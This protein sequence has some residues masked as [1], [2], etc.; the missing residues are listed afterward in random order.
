M[1]ISKVEDQTAKSKRKIKGIHETRPPGNQKITNLKL[2]G[3]EERE[4]SQLQVL[5]NIFNKI[6]EENFPN[7]REEKSINIEEAETKL[8]I[9]EQKRK[10]S[11]PIKIKTLNLQ[12]EK[13]RLLKGGQKKGRLH[14]KEDPSEL[15]RTSQ[16]N[17]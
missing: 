9:L 4:E 8:I 1:R 3:M 2:R 7:L 17:L 14:I 13:E 11:C 12:G 5:E 10:S 15:Y 16:Q 6:T